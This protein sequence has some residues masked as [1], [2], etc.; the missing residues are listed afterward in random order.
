MD[1]IHPGNNESAKDSDKSLRELKQFFWHSYCWKTAHKAP[2]PTSLLHK[3]LTSNLQFAILFPRE[4]LKSKDIYFNGEI[5]Y[6]RN[7]LNDCL[8]TSAT[9]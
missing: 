5:L 9:N 6:L 3:R 8:F 2:D 7:E 1:N 4:Q